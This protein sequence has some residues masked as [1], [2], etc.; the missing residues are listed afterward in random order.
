MGSARRAPIPF[1]GREDLTGTNVGRFVIRSKLGAGGMGEVYYAEDTALRRPVALKRVARK[2]CTDP[3]ARRRILREAQR[4]SALTSERIAGIHDVLEENGEV[5]VVMEYVHG[6]TLRERLHQPMPVPEFFQI[7]TQCA[8]ALIAAHEHGIVHCDIKPENIML[9]PEGRVKILDFGLAK[10]LPR[11]DQSSTMA[12]SG[13]LAGTPGYIPPE[14]LLEGVPDGRTDIFSLGI[15]FYEMLTMK[16]PFHKGGFVATSERTLHETPTA[17]RALNPCVPEPL[18]AIIMKAM[19]KAPPQRYANACELLDDLHRVQA[20]GLPAKS[21]LLLPERKQW[22]RPL[23]LVAAVLLAMGALAF[24]TYRWTHRPPLLAERGWVLISDFEAS[25]NG[26]IPDKGVREGLT[27]ALQQSRY[28]NVFPR[29]RVY[30]VLRRMK[31]GDARSIDESLGREICQRENLQVLLTGSIERLG[32]A[33][34]ITV[35]AL[36]PVQG[37]LLFAERERFDRE[38]QFFE[39]ADGLAKKM[40]EDLGE[41]LD[42]IEKSSRPL[43][44]VTTDSLEALQFYSRA[45]DAQDQGSD[46]KVEGLLKAALRLDPDFAMAHLQLGQY[47]STAVGKNGRAVAE[48][49]RAYQLR[50]EVTEREQYRIEAGYYGIQE[51]YEDQAQ[52]LGI[53]TSRYPD[54]EQAHRELAGAYHDTGH[55]DRAIVEL[56]E[57][58]RLNPNSAPA[59]HSLV[60]YLARSNQAEAATALALEALQRG[61]DSPQLHWGIGLIYL[62]RGDVAAARQEF[63]RIGRATETDRALQDLNLVVADLYQGKLEA[64]RIGLVKQIQAAPQEGSG[65]QAIRYDLLGR[66]D[67]TQGNLRNAIRNADLILQTPGAALQIFDLLNAGVLYARAGRLQQ[68]R[69]LLRR[70]DDLRKSLPTSWNQSCFHNLEGEIWMA[71]GQPQEA[72][73]SFASAAQEIPQVDSHAGLATA[74]QAQQRW[75]L[76]ASEWEQVLRSKEE[77]LQNG[78][79]PDL[80]FA[81]LQL[82]RA[83]DRLNQRD[84]ARNHYREVLRMWQDADDFPLLRQARGES[85]P[86]LESPSASGA[87][88]TGMSGPSSNTNSK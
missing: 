8:E 73:K 66:I 88:Q 36:D 55:L 85:R 31:K 56:R 67:L 32:Q 34:Q 70:L 42:R 80:A 39:K 1:P 7:A 17:I 15:V 33:F 46:E 18:Q 2:F 61:V 40:R 50:Q 62:G 44:K 35:R 21:T 25:G 48:L 45:T 84:L 19:A 13:M 86:I 54:D 79:P 22:G 47:Y 29:A 83:Y 49:E 64:A 27:I 58:L 30:E 4:A 11:S 53:L 10:H 69:A 20:G 6:T 87:A 41:S 68:A 76:A 5:F 71:A 82:A 3:E 43:A 14:V 63:Q 78:F 60:I 16:N 77:I 74:Y 9:T 65:L 38:D 37:N 52:A 72:A 26:P 59:Y 57:V 12:L 28:V 75:D 51:R 24:V 23:Q 81:D